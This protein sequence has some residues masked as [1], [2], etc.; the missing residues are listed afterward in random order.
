MQ[1]RLLTICVSTLAAVSLLLVAYV[2]AYFGFGELRSCHCRDGD[3]E[4]GKE[5]IEQ[6]RYFPYEWVETLYAPLI[7]WETARYGRSPEFDPA[8]WP[9]FE[10]MMRERDATFLQDQGANYA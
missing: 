4:P 7:E 3:T 8:F 9:R 1:G 10:E 2:G 5:W 6:R